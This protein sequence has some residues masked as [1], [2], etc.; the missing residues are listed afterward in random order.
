MVFILIKF[1][2]KRENIDTAK[3]VGIFMA[4]IGI[5]LGYAF[6]GGIT[7]A[8]IGVILGFIVGFTWAGKKF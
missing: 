1:K 4:I 3:S 8:F 5:F 6:I 2:R 7:G